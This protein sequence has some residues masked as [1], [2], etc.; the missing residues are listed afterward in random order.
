VHHR[1]RH[2]EGLL[3]R[4]APHLA[5]ILCAARVKRKLLFAR[6]GAARA[7]R[8]SRLA[9]LGVP[10]CRMRAPSSGGARSGGMRGS[11]AVIFSVSAALAM[12][13]RAAPQKGSSRAPPRL[14][15]PLPAACCACA[16]AGDMDQNANARLRAEL[17]LDRQQ[18]G[19]APSAAAGTAAAALKFALNPFAAEFAGVPMLPL[20]DDGAA[21]SQRQR[22]RAS[23]AMHSCLPSSGL[24][25]SPSARIPCRAWR[26]LARA[27]EP[28]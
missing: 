4:R 8:P 18:R 11:A 2:D 24:P 9:R 1:H 21:P 19:D 13:S 17:D 23:V 10:R 22:A 7:Q 16:R 15:P 20:K 25:Q 27:A 5:A 12:R 14:T 6:G 3:R 26:A 28:L